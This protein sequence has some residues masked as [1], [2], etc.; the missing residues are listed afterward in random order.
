L[1]DVDEIFRA[2]PELTKEEL[3]GCTYDFQPEDNNGSESPEVPK[4]HLSGR[5]I[6]DFLDIRIDPATNFLGNRW[7]TKGS[8]AFLIAPSGHGK[9]SIS[10]YLLISFSIGRVAF[11]IK[12]PRPLR[13]LCVESE[14][15]DAEN[16]KFSQVIHKMNLTEEELELLRQNTRVEYRNDLTGREFLKALDDWLTE[17][18]ADVIIINPITGFFL[19]DLKDEEK[20][21]FFL[22]GE[23]NPILTK[24]GCA[25][26]IV[27]HTPKTN[28]KKLAEMEWYDWMYAM[29]GCASL[30]NWARA[31]LV[32]APSKTPGTYRLIAAKRFDEIQWAEREYWFSHHKE[33]IIV[34]GE[35]IEIIQWVPSTEAQ[36]SGAKPAEKTKK[37]IPDSEKVWEKM[38]PLEEYTRVRFEQWCWKEFRLGEKKAWSILQDL[39]ADGLVKVSKEKRPGTNPLKKYRKV[40]QPASANGS[41]D[42]IE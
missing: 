20:V 16:K 28:F 4:Y 38:T 29:A 35:L 40:H 33:K 14:D 1:K 2:H 15:D 12:P 8:G 5:N 36:I 17:W 22:R 30:T 9:S 6:V 26:F 31:V 32:L 42:Q 13:I 37:T 10:I 27:H 23:L 39:C 18:P 34:T 7:L 3:M 21:A 11:A 25:A 19:G 24:H 41:R